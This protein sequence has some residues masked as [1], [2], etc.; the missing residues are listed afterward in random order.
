MEQRCAISSRPGA[1][2]ATPHSPASLFS[3]LVLFLVI[4]VLPLLGTASND[5]GDTRYH[6]LGHRLMCTCDAEPAAMGPKGC[7]QVL[8][9]CTHYNCE[10]S[11]RMRGELRA[12][13][14]TADTDGAVLNS[15]V[16]KYGTGVLVVPRMSDIPTRLWVITFAIL[17]A[18]AASILVA[19]VR[20]WHSRPT[21]AGMPRSDSQD[22]APDL[23]HGSGRTRQ[24]TMRDNG[25]V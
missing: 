10:T 21:V 25:S 22:I 15:F 3:R 19:F 16:Q 23:L 5:G 11:K 4:S 2:S 14:Q 9:E 12:A 13:L 6:N 7:R 20:K 1:S 24:A 18:A 17:L 8:L